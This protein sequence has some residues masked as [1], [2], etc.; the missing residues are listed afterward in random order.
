MEEPI[1]KSRRGRRLQI[2]GATTSLT[3]EWRVQNTKS[4]RRETRA[5]R[6]RPS[7]GRTGRERIATGWPKPLAGSVRLRIEPCVEAAS[8]SSLSEIITAM[9]R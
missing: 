9:N 5:C 3:P 7:A 8:P 4:E 6:A 1:C 2:G